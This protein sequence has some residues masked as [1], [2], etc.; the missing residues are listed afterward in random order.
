MSTAIEKVRGPGAGSPLTRANFEM[1]EG[2]CAARTS[3]DDR[4]HLELFLLYT[5]SEC[6]LDPRPLTVFHNARDFETGQALL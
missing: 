3:G 2:V 6:S 1:R 5:A 4:A